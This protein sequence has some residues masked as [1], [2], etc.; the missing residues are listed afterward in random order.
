MGTIVAVAGNLASGKTTLA[1][2][3]ASHNGWRRLPDQGY[4]ASYIDDL[5]SD[6]SRWAF[7]AQVHFLLRKADAV[8]SGM[9]SQQTVA[10]DRSISEDIDIFARYFH[11][12][13]WISHRSY[14][15]YLNCADWIIRQL[16]PPAMVVY[17]WAPPDVCLARLGRRPRTYQALYPAGHV[18]RLHERY[19]RWWD[20]L[21]GPAKVRIETTV[22]DLRDPSVARATAQDVVSRLPRP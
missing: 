16:V 18:E 11:E 6:P 9:R 1:T 20:A 10:L 12:Q 8:W 21:A 22:T 13:G 4:E 5:F 19:E 3:L 2:A 14:A 15:L 17:C 7:E